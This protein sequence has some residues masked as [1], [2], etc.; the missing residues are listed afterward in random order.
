MAP[1]SARGMER[2]SWWS[3]SSDAD[4]AAMGV[5]SSCATCRRKSSFSRS[6]SACAVTSRTVWIRAVGCVPIGV[7]TSPSTP[8]RSSRGNQARRI[9][10]S[11]VSW[12]VVA[13]LTYRS[14]SNRAPTSSS[15][16]RRRKAAG[17]ALRIVP[18]ASVMTTPSVRAMNAS[19]YAPPAAASSLR[20][21]GLRRRSASGPAFRRDAEADARALTRHGVD[22]EVRADE[23]GRLAHLQEPEAAA[24]RVVRERRRDV[25]ALAVIL[26]DRRERARLVQDID[27]HVRR[28]AGL[29]RVVHGLAYDGERSGLDLRPEAPRRLHV[30]RLHARA[31]RAIR[32]LG[33]RAHSGTEAALLQDHRP[34][35]EEDVPYLALRG[36]QSLAHGA[37]LLERPRRVGP[38]AALRDLE[39]HRGVRQRLGN[40]VV[41]LAREPVARLLRHL[42]DAQPLAYELLVQLQ[43]LERDARRAGEREP[44]ALVARCELAGPAVHDLEHA[45]TTAVA[46]VDRQDEHRPRAVAGTRIDA[47]VEPRVVVRMIDA[48]RAATTRDLGREAGAVEREPD[49]LDL[50]AR[51]H[52]GPELLPVLVDDVEGRPLGVEDDRRCLGDAPDDDVH[53]GLERELALEIEQRRELL[54]LARRRHPRRVCGDYAPCAAISRTVSSVSISATGLSGRSRTMRGKRSA[55]PES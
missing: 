31:V 35:R 23:A 9:V 27:V 26:D 48:Q 46:C 22:G 32:P 53:I 34:Q 17:F 55:K 25:E 42:H 37:E 30:A 54:C 19:A 6:S 13:P 39:P 21:P 7:D 4:R 50:R 24:L 38:P 8:M 52:A 11:S 33:E 15:S 10:S 16:P 28:T 43:V 2:A 51:E 1:S 40:A 49:L 20:R 18:S 5:R 45:E 47:R 3:R 44:E 29:D 41:E 12:T 14:S 36:E